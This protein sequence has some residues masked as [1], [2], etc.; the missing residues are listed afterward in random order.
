LTWLLMRT[1][2]QAE[3]RA[4]Q[5][6]TRFKFPNHVF[7]HEMTRPFRGR[8]VTRLVPAFSTYL[9]AHVT[10][11][12]RYELKRLW[13]FFCLLDFVSQFSA[14]RALNDLLSYALPGDVLPIDS[15]QGSRFKFGDK[16]QIVTDHHAAFG[17]EGLYQ[18]TVKPGRVCILSPWLGQMVPIEVNESD[19]ELTHQ[20][21][22]RRRGTRGRHR[23]GGRRHQRH[24][25]R[26]RLLPRHTQEEKTAAVA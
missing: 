16:V 6:L 21:A 23:R 2:P 19:V 1:V 22:T 12:T 14:D 24:Q 26:L 9:F 25:R 10:Y 3:I 18:Y 7:K 20:I 5:R 11:D 8:L 17:C 15:E 4:S 13:D